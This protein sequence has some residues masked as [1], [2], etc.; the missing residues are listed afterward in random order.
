MTV[1]RVLRV[2]RFLIGPLLA[3]LQ[4]WVLWGVCNSFALMGARLVQGELNAA[5]ALPDMVRAAVLTAL[6]LVLAGMCWSWATRIEGSQAAM[7]FVIFAVTATLLPVLVANRAEDRSMP[8]ELGLAIRLMLAAAIAG[9]FY[10]GANV[11]RSVR[12]RL[13]QKNRVA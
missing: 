1:R 8:L 3:L 9:A 11:Q 2:V 13:L 5:D 12:A 10:L 4:S 6:F 7:W